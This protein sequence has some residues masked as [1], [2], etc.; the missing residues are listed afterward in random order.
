MKLAQ[1]RPEYY[2]VEKF[3]V[4]VNDLDCI[5]TIATFSATL[6]WL[7]FPRQGIWLRDQE[8]KDYIA[9]FRYVAYLTGTPDEYFETP[10]RAKAIME[11]LLRDEIDPSPTS[12]ILANNILNCL[13]GQPPTFAS[14]SFLEANCRW[15]N[16]NELCDRLG[17]GK[18]SLYYLILMA[19]QVLFFMAVC[20]TYRSISILDQRKIR[21]FRRIIWAVIVEDK[22]GLGAESVFEFKY[23][24]DLSKTTKAERGRGALTKRGG[25]EQRN[26]LAFLLG[27]V[28]ICGML[29]MT[30]NL[31]LGIWSAAVLRLEHVQERQN[32]LVFGAL[33]LNHKECGD[34]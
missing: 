3:G 17:I 2:D 26:L 21:A 25:V 16:G 20:Y 10:S 34:M 9:L 12:Q 15:L 7:S 33:R 32:E 23:V 24:P 4:P 14:R 31:F 29:W 28:F 18:P 22:Q 11:T 1:K 8:I 5:A 19:G 30:T 6:I 13:E 27:C